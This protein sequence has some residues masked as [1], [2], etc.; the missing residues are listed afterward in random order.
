LASAVSQTILLQE[1]P[2]QREQGSV[3]PMDTATVINT[4]ANVAVAVAV[5]SWD[6]T[7][8]QSLSAGLVPGFVITVTCIQKINDL[9]SQL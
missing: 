1:Q 5:P 2:T 6:N 4:N 9:W 7:L 3:M 8:A